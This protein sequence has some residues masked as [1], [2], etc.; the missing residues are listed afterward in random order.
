MIVELD[1]EAALDPGR[2]GPKAAWLARARRSRLPVLPG[3]AVEAAAS[4]HHMRI[5]AEAL[6]RRGSGGARLAVSNEELGF[7]DD[8]VAA[9]TA[10]ADELVARSSSTLEDR[11]EWAGAFTSY[12]DLAPESLPTGVV[13]CWASAFSVDALERQGVA[14]VEP[15]SFSMAVLVQPALQPRAGGTA[16]IETDGSIIVDGV[17]GHPAPLLGGWSGGERTRLVE[18]GWKDEGL[19]SLMGRR[20]LD[21]LAAVLRSAEDLLGATACEWAVDD[22]L[23]ILQLGRDPVAPPADPPI[24][25]A[26]DS[27]LVREAREMVLADVA[28]PG[29]TARRVGRRPWEP[30]VAAVTLAA[31]D[32]SHGVPAAPGS[33]AGLAA[34]IGGREDAFVPR[35]V[36]VAE[37]PAPF[38]APLLWDAAGLVTRLGSPAAHLF[39]SA[40]ALGIPAVCGVEVDA[41]PDRIV[42]VDGDT[43]VV[44]TLPLSDE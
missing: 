44:A 25:G 9:G 5:G 30:L 24:D 3:F 17:A 7:A 6:A 34:R 33:G 8:L 37:R 32:R 39:R 12:L 28:T 35:G 36:V 23:W 40:R 29:A 41:S 14:G 4:L 15:G 42:A 31:G 16:R 43:G 21:E 18:G 11:A 2:V 27:D 1:E 20:D 26:I 38:L 22:G 10:V 13:G 19:A